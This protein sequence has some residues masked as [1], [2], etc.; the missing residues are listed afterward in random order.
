MKFSKSIE[1]LDEKQVLQLS[2]D[3]SENNDYITETAGFI[4]LE[5]KMRQFEQNGLIAQFQVS[6]F[7]SNDYREMYLNPDFNITPE[8]DFEDV[9]EKIRARNEFIEQYKK[10]KAAENGGSAAASGGKADE[11]GQTEEEVRRTE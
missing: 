11:V 1:F 3:L 2:A 4:P 6:D 5:V 9:E 7:D 10:T 8:D